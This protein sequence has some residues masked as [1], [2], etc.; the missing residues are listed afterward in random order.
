MGGRV[1]RGSPRSRR[2][3][4]LAGPLNL[5]G[6]KFAS[7]PL[8]RESGGSLNAFPS[9]SRSPA[10][11]PP[12]KPDN[13]AQRIK[14]LRATNLLFTP[15]EERFDRITRLAS[16]L[17]GTPIALVTLVADDLQWFKSVQGLEATDTPREVSF[18]GHAILSED[19][20]VVGNARKDPRFSDNPLVTGTPNIRAY[21]GHP[22][23]TPDG[24][25]VGT[26]CV[27]DR[28]P[29]KFTQ[30]QL[31]SLRDLAAVAESELE[32]RRHG[33]ARRQISL[34]RDELKRKASIDGTTRLWNQAAVLELLDAELA[35]AKRGAPTCVLLAEIDNFQNLSDKQ[36]RKGSADLLGE[37][38]ARARRAVRA[39][40]IV[41]YCGGGEFIVVLSDCG[42]EEAQ[43]VS[44]RIRSFV[45]HEGIQTPKGRV[46]VT[47]SIG[48]TL[49]D[50]MLDTPT[51]VVAAAA[52]A[53]QRA[54][55]QGGNRVEIEQAPDIS[56][57]RRT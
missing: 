28:R 23:R 2:D 45:S 27:I 41:G 24:S 54:R 55:E 5:Q 18:C 11:Q 47:I 33:E 22:L 50:S 10:V 8:R 51:P 16:H 39:F 9:N 42:L 44:E 36:G 43:T 56:N 17:L 21:V 52:A 4:G 29:R 35:R 25:Q 1:D 48:L 14:A 3:D 6:A 20:F 53:M 46:D 26:L 12:L 13:E 37:L 49:C 34:E 38:A 15:S 19:T 30:K 32:N 31:R 57:V 40:D 7:R